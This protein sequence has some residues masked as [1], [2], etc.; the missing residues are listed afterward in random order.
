MKILIL[1]NKFP[2]PEKDGYAIAVMGMIQGFAEAGH[3]VTLLAL[4]TKKH[5][6]FLQSVPDWLK[7]T[8]HLYA[9]D[10]NTDYSYWD[11][12]GNLLFSDE[13][14]HIQRFYSKGFENQLAEILQKGNFD[15]VQL[16]GLYLT[17]YV[18]TIRAHSQ[19]A[20]VLRA[21]NL[22][23]EIWERQ[24]KGE[25]AYFRRTYLQE[26]AKRIQNYEW[27]HLT[28]DTYDAIVPISG[29]DAKIMKQNKVRKP[30]LVS[31]YGVEL[32]KLK[33]YD[34]PRDPHSVFFIGALDW[35]PNLEG[36]TWFVETVWK[37]I[38][39]LYPQM[40][41]YIAGRNMDAG[42][43]MNKSEADGIIKVGE[44]E[45]AQQF[46]YEKG[47]MVVPLFSGS[48]IRIKIIEGMAM[49][50]AIIATEVAMEGNPA[51]NGK[52]V[53]VAGEDNL[54]DFLNHLAMFTEKPGYAEMFGRQAKE[55]ALATFDRKK[56]IAQLTQFY[57]GLKKGGASPSKPRDLFS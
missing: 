40:K 35:M 15:V 33:T 11:I 13:P 8:A 41:F 6:T 46:M 38:H 4:N 14:I 18:P 32:S 5:Y 45:D 3:E 57:Q 25:T 17:V 9:I 52:H 16:E 10:I 50:K 42:F 43:L 44:I 2:Y 21:H 12:I 56:I 37:Q 48:G 26:L 53:I 19:A 23:Y 31:G 24:A 54:D 7:Q 34:T 20:V 39:A 49:G 30:M 36:L 28:G 55:Y 27:K 1:S 51:E 29:R 22:E 47:V